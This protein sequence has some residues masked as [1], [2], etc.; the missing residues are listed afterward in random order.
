MARSLW[1]F[2]ASGCP[3]KKERGS[4][5]PLSPPLP[6]PPSLP[7]HKS[8]S[9]VLQCCRRT[10]SSF[11]ES[12]RLGQSGGSWKPANAPP[13]PPPQPLE[14]AWLPP[15][16]VIPFPSSHAALHS[17]IA[18]GWNGGEVDHGV[19]CGE[20]DCL[21]QGF[22]C[23]QDSELPDLTQFFHAK[24]TRPADSHTATRL[25]VPQV[26][27][28]V[29]M[30]GEKFRMGKPRSNYFLSRKNSVSWVRLFLR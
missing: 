19:E 1:R 21:L 2:G 16:S 10:E 7:Q 24:Q 14:E 13:N 20:W 22:P 29:R 27:D 5:D 17:H 11:S 28:S 9:L 25:G 23:R 18:V 30:L 26:M 3:G 8:L 4:R 6:F 12:Q 15:T